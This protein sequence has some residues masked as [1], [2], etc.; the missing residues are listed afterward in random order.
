[1]QRV[2]SEPAMTAMFAGHASAVSAFARSTSIPSSVSSSV[3]PGSVV[4]ISLG[5]IALLMSAL[6]LS[7]LVLTSPAGSR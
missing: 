1:M 6:V 4:S 3:L 7:G 5:A 2:E